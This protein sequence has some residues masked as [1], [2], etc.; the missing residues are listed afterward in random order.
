MRSQTSQHDAGRM[1]VAATR[2]IRRWLSL[3][4]G[5]FMLLGAATVYGSP[6]AS[7][8]A[9]Q[10][11]PIIPYSWSEPPSVDTPTSLNGKF[12]FTLDDGGAGRELW[13]SDGT[14]AGTA[15]VRDINPGL[16]GA[17]PQWLTVVNSRLFFTAT[18]AQNGTE[19][20]ISDGTAAGTTLV[21]DINP[22]AANSDP[23]Q[24]VDVNGT[25]FFIANDGS[26]GPELWR[27]DGAPAGTTLVKD[28]NPG[29][30]GSD[31][32]QLTAVNGIL[33]FDADDGV[34]GHELWRSDGTPAGTALVTDINPGEHSGLPAY[35]YLPT[36]IYV[37]GSL[38]FIAETESG[39]RGL[40]KSDGTA[41]GTVL[42]QIIGLPGARA[43]S[44]LTLVNG[45]LFFV[46]QS[47][48]NGYN[49]AQYTLWKSDGTAA[50]TIA[51]TQL[52]SQSPYLR[53][54]G[55]TNLNGTLLFVDQDGANHFQLW[56]SDGSA[57]GTTLVH[58]FPVFTN[59]SKLISINATLFI[60]VD[61]NI[62][63]AGIWRSDGTP[64]GT[65]LLQQTLAA[66]SMSDVNGTLFFL[67]ASFDLF[68]IPHAQL[69]KSDGTPAGTTLITPLPIGQSQPLELAGVGT[70]LFFANG[71]DL[72][73]T[74]G[75]VAGTAAI[76][77]PDF[78]QPFPRSLT[79]LNG[80]LV[81]AA[82]GPAGLELWQSDGTSITLVKDIAPGS[83]C[84]ETCY[85][86]GSAPEQLTKVDGTLFFS[87]STS[88]TA[89]EL[90]KSD[91]T[92]AGAMLVKDINPGG[93]DCSMGVCAFYSASPIQLTPVNSTLFFSADDGATGRELWKSDGTPAG[94]M[95]VK[96]IRP[97]TAGAG[98]AQLTNVAGTLFFIAN[99]GANGSELWKSDGTPAG[100]ALVKD[101]AA[102]ASDA[103]IGWLTAVG[104]RLFFAASDATTGSE[105]WT[106][107]GTPAGTTLVKDIFPGAADANPSELTDVSGTLFFAASDGASGYE[108]WKSDGTS[109]GTTLVKDINPGSH[110]SIPTE[111]T[112]ISGRLLFVAR[113]GASGAEPWI[114]DGSASGTFEIQDIAPGA[115]GSHPTKFASTSDQIYFIANEG[116]AG[117]SLWS[118]PFTTGADP[119]V[120]LQQLIGT[121]PSRR[122]P[123]TVTHANDGL[124]A[125]ADVTLRAT[126]DPELTYIGD[127]SGIT[128]TISGNLLSW[129]IGDL[130]MI[131]RRAFTVLID[132]PAAAY[133]TRYRIDWEMSSSSTDAKLDNNQQSVEILIA[134]Q[135]FA[136]LMRR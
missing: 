79:P 78:Q 36:F 132:A 115:T 10:I 104:G 63:G 110:D 126:F 97:G 40:W 16:A 56:K 39:V 37:N 117:R 89:R 19:L 87:A 113:D 67:G 134:R 9:V 65:M 23:A 77:M 136:P 72:W 85:A 42:V 103:N 92:P 62:E 86:N 8:P 100:T 20:W 29:A 48:G 125:A 131:N 34:S 101:I 94:T 114:S 90:W 14:A 25:L 73:K 76:T 28:I 112:N 41:T 88:E 120:N 80:R 31:A 3:I 124:S 51:V 108:L 119:L 111:L 109:A 75:A 6:T 61:N 122:V 81:F 107:D 13:K 69:W 7:E 2:S 123:I 47:S 82:S 24:L 68:G 83:S 57:A 45:T 93:Y 30:V 135:I 11:A 1:T 22:G 118:L 71:F 130:P 35:F 32:R 21:K 91:G 54:Y 74:D 129:N 66:Q 116:Q 133:G 49:T 52:Q 38:F 98:L 50:G 55:L 106:S 5:V 26:S 95:L 44:E 99:D 43:P 12:F 27:S 105:L 84:S 59:I 64:G 17:Y 128:P 46:V 4:V 53:P 70:T 15:L 33:L 18:D 60:G 127:T 96:D 121:A 102:G 58:S